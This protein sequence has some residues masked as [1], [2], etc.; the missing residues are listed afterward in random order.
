MCLCACTHQRMRYPAHVHVCRSHV[1]LMSQYRSAFQIKIMGSRAR[2]N[3]RERGRGAWSM[4]S[5]GGGGGI[6]EA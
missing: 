4:V 3:E 5:I 2:V 6:P 1:F